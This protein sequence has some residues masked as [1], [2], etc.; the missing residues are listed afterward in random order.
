MSSLGLLASGNPA[1]GTTAAPVLKS[2]PMSSILD[3]IRNC[4]VNRFDPGQNVIQQGDETGR[5]Y[6]LID[7]EV[8]VVKNDVQ[9]ATAKQPG[10][11]FGEMAIL[12]GG[13]HTATVR[14]LKPSS[15]YVLENPREFLNGS[16]EACLHLCELLARRIDALNRYLVDVKRQFEGHD[17]I[18]M[19]DGVL[20]TLMH[21]HTGGRVR[22]KDSTIRH[23]ELPG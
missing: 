11:V 6:V 13:P 16:P 4:E 8:E 14:A 12:L 23:G 2:R 20:E 9:V 10:A 1:T 21:R 7:G 22:P 17:H 19:V 5:L 18:G 3:L 15:F